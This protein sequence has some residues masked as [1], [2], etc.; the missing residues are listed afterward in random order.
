VTRLSSLLR[1]FVKGVFPTEFAV[2]VHF[3]P[4]GIVLLVFHLVVVAL[5]ALCAGQSNFYSHFSAPP[6]FTGFFCLP[7][8][9]NTGFWT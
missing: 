1:F 8:K 2:F 5:L 3:E 7:R 9:G 6:D 4:V